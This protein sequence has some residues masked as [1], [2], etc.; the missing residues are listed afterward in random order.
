MTEV[1]TD[2]HVGE[3]Y[4]RL[5]FP[6]VN[7]L[8]PKIETFI[9]VGKNLSDEDSEDTW[10]FQFVDGYAK[11]GSI[12]ESNDGDRKV[13]LATDKDLEDMLDLTSLISELEMASKRR[14]AK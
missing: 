1:N 9:F 5:T 14:D 2:Y 8:Y 11:Y 13:C 4:Y 10:H 12:L 3:V 6:D 7:L